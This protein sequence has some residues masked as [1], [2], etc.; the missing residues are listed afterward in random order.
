MCV[1]M[2]LA[3]ASLVSVRA[4]QPGHVI[5]ILWRPY[6]WPMHVCTFSRCTRSLPR[7]LVAAA[8][9]N[10]E[11][12]VVHPVDEQTLTMAGPWDGP[13]VKCIKARRLACMASTLMSESSLTHLAHRV[14]SL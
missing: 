10:F 13:D 12:T 7:P 4:A 2:S 8:N 5:R 3:L 14:R 1:F 6:G 9:N 11:S